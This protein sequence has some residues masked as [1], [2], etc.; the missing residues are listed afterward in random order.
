MICQNC[1]KNNATA[2]LHSVSNGIVKDAYL[3]SECAKAFKVTEFDNNDLFY[4][5]YNL[6]VISNSSGQHLGFTFSLSSCKCV[7]VFKFV[8]TL[9]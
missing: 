5:I 8:L 7:C 4:I 1:K 6:I 2:H 9:P 3:C